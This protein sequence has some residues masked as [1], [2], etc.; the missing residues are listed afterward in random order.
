MC[1]TV[2]VPF[3]IIGTLIES[4]TV[5]T[6]EYF[7]SGEDALEGKTSLGRTVLTW[8]GFRDAQYLVGFIIYNTKSSN[9]EGSDFNTVGSWHEP[10]PWWWLMTVRL[11]TL[12][13]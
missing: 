10:T 6:C 11:A 8:L 13:C 7:L 3:S 9:F 4:V 2:A 1:V 5:P 12:E